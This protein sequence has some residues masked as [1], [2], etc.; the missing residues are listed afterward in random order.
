MKAIIVFAILVFMLSLAFAGLAGDKVC[1]KNICIQVETAS[2][3]ETRAQGL[4]FR[5]SLGQNTGM[6]F[7]FESEDKHAFWMKNMKLPLDIIW[8]NK[9][10]AIVDI[11]ENVPPCGEYC[12]TLIPAQDARYV[13][14]VSS[15]FTEEHSIEIGDRVDLKDAVK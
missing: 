8:I 5:S 10:N 14:E 3:P 1:I 6:L 11:K 12:E 4:M 9:D 13:L 15:G 2:S 7:I